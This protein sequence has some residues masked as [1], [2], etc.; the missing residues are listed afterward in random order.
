MN[1]R[2][3][4]QAEVEVSG[5]P[6]YFYMRPGTPYADAI[7]AAEQVVEDLKELQKRQEAAEQQP[8]VKKEEA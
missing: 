6:Y 4:V 2:A 5:R 3:M 8:D 7:K 1:I